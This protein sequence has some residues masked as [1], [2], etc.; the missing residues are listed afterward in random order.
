[1]YKIELNSDFVELS[2][3]KFVVT[4]A[5]YDAEG[6]ELY[7]DGN[8]G[9]SLECGDASSLQVIVYAVTESLPEDRLIVNSPPFAL[10]VTITRLGEVIYDKMH[11]VNQWGGASINITI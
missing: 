2:R 6:A 5:G 3:Y 4:C 11:E 9:M 1:M 7:V 10:N 8:V